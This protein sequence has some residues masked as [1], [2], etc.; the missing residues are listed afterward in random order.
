MLKSS[1]WACTSLPRYI[2]SKLCAQVHRFYIPAPNSYRSE[3]RCS[4]GASSLDCFGNRNAHLNVRRS[5]LFLKVNET[6]VFT[7][8][9]RFPGPDGA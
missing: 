4:D 2:I 3:V 5:D 9:R 1:F 8:L 7:P 6:R